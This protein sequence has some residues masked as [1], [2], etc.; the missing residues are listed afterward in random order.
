MQNKD[1]GFGIEA[2]F[3]LVDNSSY[4]PFGYRD[5]DFETLLNIVDD[6]QTD[7]FSREGFN[8]KPLH[9]QISPYLIEG[10]TLTD[11]DMKPLRLLPKGIEIR[12]PMSSTV[13]SSTESLIELYARLKAKLVQSK[14]NT[15]MI[16]YHPT[17]PRIDA[18][19]N[20][21]RH[22]YWQW[23]LTATTTYGPDINISL[24][25]EMESKVDTDRVNARV[26]YY[27]PAAI[28]L[29]LASPIKEGHLW[30]VDGSAGKSVRTY[31]RS[32]WAPIFYVHEKPS[33]RFEFKGFEMSTNLNDYHAMFLI[34]LALLL[35][36]RLIQTDSDQNRISALEALAVS[37]VDSEE[38]RERSKHLLSGAERIAKKFGLDSRSLSEFW[39]RLEKGQLPSDQIAET[40]VQTGSVEATLRTLTDFKVNCESANKNNQ[41]TCEVG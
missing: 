13:E 15:A 7:D 21:K 26:N 10:Y 2:E 12:T 38:V 20:Y 5:L 22:D 41:T 4:K 16:S 30:T 6:I 23:A 33:L 34:G 40:F 8:K 25:G 14:M 35:D 29:T 9:N 18:P 39:H 17:E 11:A 31:E 27:A 19:P 36:E 24:P 28:A 3:L 1:F 37:G 32:K